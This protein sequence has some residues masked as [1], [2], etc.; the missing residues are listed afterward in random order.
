MN[1]WLKKLKVGDYVLVENRHDTVLTTVSGITKTQIKVDSTASFS[2]N[3]GGRESE[4]WYKPY[5]SKATEEIANKLRL[6]AAK[7]ELIDM[8][9]NIEW[10]QM[11]L[12]ALQSLGE[13]IKKEYM[14]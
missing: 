4:G 14:E 5:L 9:E 3:D 1:E 11:G 6:A 12:E 2:I 7:K 13:S 10:S 8:I